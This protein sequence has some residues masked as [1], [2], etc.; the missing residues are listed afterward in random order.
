MCTGPLF[1]LFQFILNVRLDYRLSY[2]LS[3]FKKEFVDVYPMGDADATSAVERAG[4][5]Y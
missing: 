2:L 1:I 5:Q 3:V 4:K